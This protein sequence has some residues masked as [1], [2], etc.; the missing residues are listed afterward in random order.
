MSTL[1]H[2]TTYNGCSQGRL[3]KKLSM[4]TGDIFLETQFT[5]FTLNKLSYMKYANSQEVTLN[6]TK[7]QEM[8]LRI[9]QSLGYGN[10]LSKPYI[11]E[12]YSAPSNSNS[13]MKMLA[14]FR[15]E[16]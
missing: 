13:D 11:F 9:N 10:R 14:A 16:L 1:Y 15:L 12:M 5:N 3:D 4:S 7:K 2:K 6:L 8:Y